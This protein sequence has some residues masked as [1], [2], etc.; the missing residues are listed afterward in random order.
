MV[1]VPNK[2]SATLERRLELAYFQSLRGHFLWF[3]LGLT[4]PPLGHWFDSLP[5]FYLIIN[6]D[7]SVPDAYC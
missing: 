3:G 7:L 6:P 2:K 1:R 4:E 5:D